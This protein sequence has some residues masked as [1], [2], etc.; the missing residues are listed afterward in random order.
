MPVSFRWRTLTSNF[1][2]VSSRRS[3]S[4][5]AL[6]PSILLA[7]I[8][9]PAGAV[10]NQDSLLLECPCELSSDGTAF[11]I[12]AAARSFRDWDS[13]QVAVVAHQIL[14][15]GSGGPSSTKITYYEVGRADLADSIPANAGL[16]R[17]TLRAEIESTPYRQDVYP[18]DLVL[19]EKGDEAWHVVDR[20]RM[21]APQNIADT[22]VI[23]DLNFLTDSDDDRVADLNERLRRTDP[24]DSTSTPGGSTVDVVVLYSEGLPELFGGDPTTR[25]QHLFAVSNEIY[26][27]SGV[28]LRLRVVGL[29]QI[30]VDEELEFAEPSYRDLINEA[31]RH[32]A[33]LVVVIRPMP[34]SAGTCGRAYLGGLGSRGRFSFEQQGSKFATVFGNCRARTL[35]HEIGHV[36]GLG[37]SV[38]QNEVGTWRWSRG[39]GVANDFGTVMTY[40]PPGGGSHRLD[41][42]SNPRNL[43]RGIQGA[44]K[45]CGLAAGEID[46]AD[47][48]TTLN[49]V[50]FQIAAFRDWRP[51]SDRDGYVDPVDELPRDPLDWRD[52][53]N[54]GLGNNRDPDDDNDGVD[55]ERDAYPLDATETADSD[56]DGF[57]DNRDAFPRDPNEASDAD[58]DG[59]GDN[60]DVFPN[61]P[62]ESIDSDGDGVGDNADPWPH[63]P[64]ES[65]DTDGD[66]IGDNA[67]PDADNDGIRNALDLFPLDSAKSDLAS[68]QF[69]GE[70]PADAIGEFLSPSTAGHGQT[71]IL[72]APEH[73][74]AGVS[75]AGAVYVLARSDLS[76]ID[77][78]DGNTDR[79]IDLGRFGAGANSWKIVGDATHYSVGSSAIFDGDVDGDGIADLVIGVSTRDGPD[80]RIAAG[81]TYLLSA[82]DFNAADT[83]DGAKD[84]RI[85]LRHVAAQPRSM[86]FV[87][88]VEYDNSGQTLTTVADADGD[89]VR[90]LVIGAPYHNLD[91]KEWVGAVYVLSSGSLVLAD[92]ADGSEDG[93]VDLGAATRNGACWKLVGDL[94][95]DLAGEV[96][97]DLGEFGGRGPSNLAVTAAQATY[98]VST[99]DLAAADA[100]DNRRD[101]VVTLDHAVTEPGSWKLTAPPGQVAALPPP[102]GRESNLLVVERY[103]VF[104]GDLASADVADGNGD[105]IIDPERLVAEPNSWKLNST[106][107]AAPVGD[108]DGD[109]I[110]EILVL[111]SLN[112]TG[113]APL[114]YLVPQTSL[115][116]ADAWDHVD[117]R[118]VPYFGLRNSPDARIVSGSWAPLNNLGNT[119]A[120]AG[121]FDGDGLADMLLGARRL[122]RDGSENLVYLLLGADVPALDA[123]DGTPDNYLEL[124]NL[125]GDLDGDGVPNTVD[126]D[127]DSDGFPDGSDAFQIDPGEWADADGDGVGDNSDAF[128]NQW[129]EQFDTDG[130][131]IGDSADMDDDGDGIPDAEDARPLDTDNDGIDNRA[132]SDDDGDGVSDEDDEL[133]YDASDSVD[134]DGDGV[135]NSTDTDDDG[136]GYPDSEDTFPLD[137]AEA[138]DADGDGVGDNGDRFPLDPDEAFDHDGDG[139]GDNADDDDDNDGVPDVEDEFPRDA[140]GSMDADGD[141][142]ADSLDAFRNDPAESVDSDGDGVGNNADNDDDNDGVA[143]AND[144]F[145]QNPSRSDLMSVRMG[146]EAA[147]DGFGEVVGTVE[148]L[149]GDHLPEYLIGAHEASPSGALYLIPSGD[150]SSTDEQDGVAD[151][152][153]AMRNLLARSNAWKIAGEE[154]FATGYL[155]PVSLGDIGG[156]GDSTFAVPGCASLSCHLFL[157]SGIDLSAADA[158]DGS[159]DGVATLSNIVNGTGSWR[160]ADVGW[161]TGPPRVAFLGDWDDDDLMDAVIGQPGRGRGEAPGTVH[162]IPGAEIP[163]LDGLDGDVDGAAHLAA[164]EGNWRLTGE[165]PFDRAGD[166]LQS[167]DFDGDGKRDLV[168]VAS[169]YDSTETGQ[170]NNGATYLVGSRDVSVADTADGTSDGLIELARVASLPNSWKL[171]GARGDVIEQVATGDVNGDGHPDLV[172]TGSSVIHVVSGN[173]LDLERLD[174][175]DETVDG[176]VRLGELEPGSGA[177]KLVSDSQLTTGKPNIV[178]MDADGDDHADL[179]VGITSSDRGTQTMAHFIPG[180]L[181]AGAQSESAVQSLEESSSRPGAYQFLVEDKSRSFR[182]VVASAGDVD[183][184]G[185]GDFLFSTND[186]GRTDSGVAY[187]IVGADLPV[188]DA[189]DGRMDGKVALSSIVRARQ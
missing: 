163:M 64:N 166:W 175:A 31:E 25:I 33:D 116:D 16:A 113:F 57:G 104:S 121:D 58:G 70:Q 94:A 96:I 128:P 71:L 125:A 167:A 87:G 171:I 117:G 46:G 178:V 185:F 12:K 5:S 164:H 75:N 141:G 56:G 152:D 181:F 17:F 34:P 40:G 143:D 139:V 169:G 159:A 138:D 126:T 129:T 177:W 161:R 135:G 7:G 51:D 52:Y 146:A 21:E 98:L 41:V 154:G 60:S 61:D 27:N 9:I 36:M 158:A 119:L 136:D 2:S 132:D 168:I 84:Q 145:P 187:L 147:R 48:A 179:L 26:R 174:S 3:G 45:P 97:V 133:P 19:E 68:Y 35:V 149:D 182:T 82:A 38:W 59:V 89:G 124:A 110:A 160:L 85:E 54:D 189:A 118:I 10:A 63:N 188:L 20:V 30:D 115:A 105:G 47:A 186:W 1:P 142:V 92:G 111:D 95:Y 6:V 83:T 165:R 15:E 28:H 120:S 101:H 81:V 148:D 180:S 76:A 91:D 55:D 172:M 134:T 102:S 155:Q 8:L 69:T 137:P 53:D 122:Q 72:R 157:V 100:A 32:G 73:D 79:V 29:V 112:S 176:V 90:E 62:L 108:S 4:L 66:G 49:S 88:E 37:H 24:G 184:D 156:N 151:G 11:T 127:D 144:L 18:F 44:D 123:T 130:D 114:G 103:L 67:D 23:N 74:H 109:G 42:F 170:S 173:G 162:V 150:F 106:A 50:R 80:G 39:H 77:A 78:A 140:S 99:N 183:K 93:V 13:G 43:C 107:R 153:L 65:A 131:G 14:S 22:F 86:R